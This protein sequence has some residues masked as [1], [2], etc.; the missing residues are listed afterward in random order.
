LTINDEG[1]DCGSAGALV[2]SGAINQVETNEDITNVQVILANDNP[3]FPKYV[4]S[5]GAY[6]FT[7]LGSGNY[8]I[9]AEKTDDYSNGVS[10]L[11][12]ILIQKHILGI[13]ALDDHYDLIA[14]DAKGNGK[15]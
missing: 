2:L 13:N 5:D 9:S 8:Q 14:S 6:Q 11:D 7:G 15:D 12:L 3:E 4:Q 1:D 10:T